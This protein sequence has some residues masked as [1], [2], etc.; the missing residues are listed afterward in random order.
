MKRRAI[1]CQRRNRGDSAGIRKFLQ[2]VPIPQEPGQDTP[3]GVRSGTANW[4]CVLGHDLSSD[5][6]LAP[7]AAPPR[8]DTALP[9][10]E[11]AGPIS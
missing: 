9:V 3:R 4:V 6:I 11:T 2:G 5:A 1:R 10:W 7:G 8:L